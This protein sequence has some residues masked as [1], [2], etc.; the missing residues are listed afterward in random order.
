MELEAKLKQATQTR[1]IATD[2]WCSL[3]RFPQIELAAQLAKA[4]A[5]RPT[6]VNTEGL[7][8]LCVFFLTMRWLILCSVGS[9]KQRSGRMWL[10][11]KN[12]EIDSVSARQMSVCR[13]ERLRRENAVLQKMIT[14]RN[15][16]LPS[17]LLSWFACCLR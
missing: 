8:S 1:V 10:N 14:E 5:A 7:R 3:T 11:R 16:G 12:C 17:G 2:F 15:A 6:H 9:I 4:R 13:C